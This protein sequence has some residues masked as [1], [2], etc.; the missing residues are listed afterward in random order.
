MDSKGVLIHVNPP[1]EIDVTSKATSAAGSAPLVCAYA[2]TPA[3]G[4]A[5]FET[6]EARDAGWLGFV[7][8]AVYIAAWN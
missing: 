8:E 5:S 2:H 7:G 1:D 4:C 3:T 6:S